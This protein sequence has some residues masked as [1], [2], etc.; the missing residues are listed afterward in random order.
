LNF[1]IATLN[2]ILFSEDGDV[3]GLLVSADAKAG[4]KAE[5][6]IST[7]KVTNVLPLFTRHLNL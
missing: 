2:E 7:N 5:I 4:V 1:S 3:L 6:R